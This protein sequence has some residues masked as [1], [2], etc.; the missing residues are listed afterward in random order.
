MP[1]TR[2]ETGL[3]LTRARA[4][5]TGPTI[6][7]GSC[8]CGRNRFELKGPKFETGIS[9]NCLLCRKSGYLWA[10]P[11]AGDI[12][13]TKGDV[14]TLSGYETEALSHEVRCRVIR[15]VY[16]LGAD[17]LQQFCNFCGTGL[18]GTHK[19]GPLEGQPGIN[20]RPPCSFLLCTY[21]LVAED[22]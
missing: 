20:V 1:I 13:Y 22:L 14:D 6:W 9:C 12:K 3:S 19:A 21:R 15:E 10:F 11:E 2:Q 5:S 16:G 7:K 4:T 18:Y 17:T 8:H